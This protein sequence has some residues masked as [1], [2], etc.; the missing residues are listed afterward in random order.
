M[1]L[2]WFRCAGGVEEMRM[3]LKF[4]K[5][6]QRCRA[7]QLSRFAKAHWASPHFGRV[8][9]SKPHDRGMGVQEFSHL[10]RDKLCAAVCGAVVLTVLF[11]DAVQGGVAGAVV[12]L[13]AM[14]VASVC[15]L[16]LTFILYE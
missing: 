13:D 9:H 1:A 2:E 15:C 12:V 4:P 16:G 3:R 8:A 14:R 11:L 10:R 7:L 5:R 6:Q